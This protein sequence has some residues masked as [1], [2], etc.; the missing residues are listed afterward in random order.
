M[1][2]VIFCTPS[3]VTL[4]PY[5]TQ[6]NAKTLEDGQHRQPVPPMCLQ[7]SHV[8]IG[9]TDTPHQTANF[10]LHA[11]ESNIK[12]HPSIPS[13]TNQCTVRRGYFSHGQTYTTVKEQYHNGIWQIPLLTSCR[14]AYRVKTCLIQWTAHTGAG[15][16]AGSEK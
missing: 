15:M 5:S 14:L 16:A 13:S 9:H 2:S 3:H 6:T 11:T 7:M 10:A 4:Q 1:T 12:P 8:P